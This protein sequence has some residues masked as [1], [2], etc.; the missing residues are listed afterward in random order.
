MTPLF[1]K[2]NPEDPLN[3]RPISVTS[4]L[5]KIFQKTLSSLITSFPER[6]Q[7]LSASQFGYRKQTSTINAILK[8]TEQIRLE[9]NKKNVTGAFLNLSKAF[10]CINHKILLRELENIGFDEHATNLKEKYLS[11]STEKVVLSSTKY[12]FRT[13]II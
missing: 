13:S 12:Y 6:E 10:D 3:Y 5:S 2:R 9:L 7:L 11:K 1:K 8:S 4:A